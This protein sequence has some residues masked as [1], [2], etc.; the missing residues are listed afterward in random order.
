MMLRDF[1]EFIRYSKPILGYWNAKKRQAQEEAILAEQLE[2]IGLPRGLAY[3]LG[4]ALK[5]ARDTGIELY[6]GM[7]Y[8]DCRAVLPRA[9]W[10][11]DAGNQDEVLVWGQFL[12]K[13]RKE[14]TE[15]QRLD[16]NICFAIAYCALF[17]REAGAI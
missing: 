3:E 17:A 11:Y 6:Q 9:H 2:G 12:R 14:V 5:F 8:G 15:I 13:T 16:T 7:T 4:T 10:K 1:V